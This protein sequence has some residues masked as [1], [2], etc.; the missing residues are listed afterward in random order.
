[1]YYTTLIFFFFFLSLQKRMTFCK[2][3]YVYE[4][5]RHCP[6]WGHTRKNRQVLG[7]AQGCSPG[8]KQAV[9]TRDWGTPRALWEPAGHVL[10]W[11]Q[12][13]KLLR[14]RCVLLTCTSAMTVSVR[15]ALIPPAELRSLN[16][17]P[18]FYSYNPVTGGWPQLG[19]RH[20]AKQG[21]MNPASG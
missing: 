14:R 5:Q 9:R 7:P 19:A 12:H 15:G 1:M 18:T 4:S 20:P 8:S 21:L 10:S 17:R 13:F 11:R 6:R 16:T 2:D 3:K